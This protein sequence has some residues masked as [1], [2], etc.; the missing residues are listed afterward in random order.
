M[1]PSMRDL[2]SPISL[3]PIAPSP[4]CCSD[5][6]LHLQGTSHN[7]TLQDSVI[8]VHHSHWNVSPR[9]AQVCIIPGLWQMFS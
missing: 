5:Y 3:H 6:C 9:K 8:P 7:L 1:F 4:L 2:H